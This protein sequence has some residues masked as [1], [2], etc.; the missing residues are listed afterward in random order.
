MTL[1]AIKKPWQ[2]TFF[3]WSVSNTFAMVIPLILFLMIQY[4][5]LFASGHIPFVGPGGMCIAFVMN[6]F[7]LIAD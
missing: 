3:T 2:R 7:R 6:L 4:I 1:T 5:P